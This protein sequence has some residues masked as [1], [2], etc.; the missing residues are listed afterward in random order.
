MEPRERD[1]VLVGSFFTFCVWIGLSVVGIFDILSQKAK[2]ASMGIAPVALIAALSVPYLLCTQ[3]FDDHSRR[4][5]TGARDY[6]SNFLNSCKPNSII[7]TY[8]DND[9]YPLWYAQEVEGIRTD[10]RVVNLSLIAVDWYISQLRRKVNNSPEIKMSIPEASYR[11]YRRNQVPVTASGP[12]MDLATALKFVGENHG[13]RSGNFE[14]YFQTGKFTLPIDVEK[15]KANGLLSPQDT[16]VVSAIKFALPVISQKSPYVIKDDLAILDLIASNINDRPIYFA[17]TCQQNKLQGLQ[18][19]MQL[20]GLGLRLVPIKSQGDP[21]FSIIGN[22]RVDSETTF[23][24]ITEEFKW[25]NF[26]KQKMYVDRSYQ[27]SVQSMRFVILRTARAL[28]QENQKEKA[29]AL[30]DKYFEGF[31]NMNFPYDYNAFYMIDTYV[32]ADAYAKA[33]PHVEI[34]AKNVMENLKFY[35]S[36]G[37]EVK[38]GFEQDYALNMRTMNDVIDAVRKGGDEAYAKQ[39]EAEFEPYNMMKGMKQQ[40]K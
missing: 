16:G 8:G 32:S 30:V 2:A 21:Q 25:G 27:P 14:S 39:L 36:I 7:F 6:A 13:D 28:I 17:V 38:N 15:M 3:N 12:E 33:K 9:T 5:H 11:G 26:D 20:E 34:L 18:D 37:T 29:A 4:G 24:K 40:P 19:F 10:V 31:P 35:R 1:Y 22:G 23:K